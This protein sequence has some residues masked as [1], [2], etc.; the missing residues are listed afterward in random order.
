MA[1]KRCVLV[2]EDDQAMRE[3]LVS[4]LEEGG[5]AT[6]SAPDAQAAVT[7]LRECKVDAV[8]SDVRMPGSSGVTMLRQLHEICPG[9]PVILMSSFRV[10][11]TETEA[12]RAGAFSYLAKPFK[13]A[14]LLSTLERAFN[15]RPEAG[16]AGISH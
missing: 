2:V 8:L 1:P 7:I 6:C 13:G 16:E 9:V 14:V 4:F 15:S 10:G 12:Q 3:M 11:A 5:V